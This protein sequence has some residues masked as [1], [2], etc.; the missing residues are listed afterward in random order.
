MKVKIHDIE[1]NSFYIANSIKE[2]HDSLDQ[3]IYALCVASKEIITM[4][5]YIGEPV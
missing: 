3:Q 2:C 1:N 4:G 5:K